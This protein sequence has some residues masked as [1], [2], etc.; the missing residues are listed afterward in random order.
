MLQSFTFP[1]VPWYQNNSEPVEKERAT[2]INWV[3]LSNKVL[4][5]LINE[6]YTNV[7]E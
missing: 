6:N 3:S 5:D 4:S 2:K 7:K 1:K